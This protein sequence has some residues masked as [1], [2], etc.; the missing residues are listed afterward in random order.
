MSPFDCIPDSELLVSPKD[1]E[2]SAKLFALS[3]TPPDHDMFSL[4]GQR[5][6]TPSKISGP[7]WELF[8]DTICS[9]PKRR[10]R[11]KSVIACLPRR[12]EVEE[13][14]QRSDGE[15]EELQSVAEKSPG[16]LTFDDNLDTDVNDGDP[17]PILMKR[18]PCIINTENFALNELVKYMHPYC[19]PAVTMCLESEDDE[20]LEQDTVFLEIVSDER[21]TIKIPVVVEPP[22]EDMLCPESSDGMTG[23]DVEMENLPNIPS[24]SDKDVPELK[25]NVEKENGV[26]DEVTEAVKDVPELQD[27][28]PQPPEIKSSDNDSH[29]VGKVVPDCQKNS[30]PEITVPVI[31]NEKQPQKVKR[32]SKAKKPSKSKSKSKTKIEAENKPPDVP[33]PIP[34]RS[35][36]QPTANRPSNPSL[37]ES[38]LLI[39]TLDQVKKESQMDLRSSKAGRAKTR[40][41]GSL[42]GSNA[43]R[44]VKVVSKESEQAKSA[45]DVGKDLVQN[46]KLE[47]PDS[48][49]TGESAVQVLQSDKEI[50]KDILV[51]SDICNGEESGASKVEDVQDG[52]SSQMKDAKPKSL[53]LS[54]YRKR[55]QHRQ[56]KPVQD[57]ENP[58]YSRWPTVPEPPTEL[59]ELPCLIVPSQP[60]KSMEDKPC[61]IKTTNNPGREVPVSSVSVPMVS[62]EVQ[63][64]TAEPCPSGTDV[65]PPAMVAPQPS[66]PPQ[67]Y[68]SVWPAVPPPPSFYPGMPPMAG[69]HHYQNTLPSVFPVQ[70]PVMSWPPFPPPPIAV[71]PVHPTGW[72]SGPPTPYWSNAQ[73]AQAMSES[74]PLHNAPVTYGPSTLHVGP[75]KE[76][77]KK[78]VVQPVERRPQVPRI[79]VKKPENSVES[80][81]GAKP[82]GLKSDS[83][84]LL[85]KA[86]KS[87]SV[88]VPESKEKILIPNLKSANQ[89]V[90]QI[91]EILKKA[92]KLGFQ[93]PTSN[94]TSANAQPVPPSASALQLKQKVPADVKVQVVDKPLTRESPAP[95]IEASLKP[96]KLKMEKFPATGMG[97]AQEVA[98]DKVA[99]EGAEPGVLP[100][101]EPVWASEEM[102]QAAAGSEPKE[103][104]KSFT[105]ESGI[106]ATDLTSLLEQFEK[107]EAK[108]EERLPRSP[109]KLAVGNSGTGKTLEKMIHEKLLAPELVNTAGLTPPATPPH[110]LWKSAATGP[111]AGK[112]RSLHVQEKSY[113]PVKTAKL[114]EPKPLPQSRLKLRSV[115]SSPSV[116][117]PPVHVASG[118]HDYCIFSSQQEGNKAATTTATTAASPAACEEGSRWNV[119][120]HPNITIKPIVQFNKRQQIKACPKQPAPSAPSVVSNQSTT[121]GPIKPI[122]PCGSIQKA[123]TDP[124]DH[125]TNV[126]AESAVASAPA[127]VLMSPDSSPCRSETGASRTDVKRGNVSSRRALRCYRKYQGSPSPQ[128]SWRGRSSSSRSDSMSSSCSCSCSSSSSRSRSGSPASKRRRTSRY[129]SR[130]RH[131]SRSSSRSGYCSS[132]SSR[133]SSCSSRSCT[134]SSSRSRSRS[135]SPYERRCRSRSRRCESRESYNRRKIYHKERA[136]EER[137]VVY[138]GKIN[139]LMTRSELRRRFSVFGD[140][141]EC[142]IHFREEGDNYGFVTYRCT[143]EAFAAIENG[144]KLRLPGELPFDLCFGGRRQFC[145]STYADLDSHRDDFDPAPVRSKFEALDFD[146]LLKQ[147]Q[148]NHRR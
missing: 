69:V 41:R 33:E 109:D 43:D 48:V 90:S 52:D 38:D 82:E 44:N 142:T 6:A 47:N 2:G 120:H 103:P 122:A 131:R 107:T 19:L 71:P 20:N 118:D 58:S 60:K 86:A 104:E 99:S 136:I 35:I 144:H 14:Q 25:V 132:D 139:S 148:K 76:L 94:A 26:Q 57:L 34:A 9:T 79:V 115:G 63:Q 50:V 4:D 88:P 74:Q 101:A 78:G 24:S 105:C 106:E 7:N 116:A 55:L 22:P 53:S 102:F 130:S 111:V 133:S 145:K 138:I 91:M 45:V 137:R 32:S 10:T 96:E 61:P 113:S 62:Q 5:R 29:T 8:P 114:I 112:P 36:A 30:E 100:R 28:P 73:M 67:F 98:K 129:R 54:E 89:V 64:L 87:P 12:A 92:Q 80:K 108:E 40:T 11:C 77:L 85:M 147:A 21:E 59:A 117:V 81:N 126:M 127:S 97:T 121:C 15:D 84:S 17:E 66:V 51:P 110:Q 16:L 83:S 39:K 46:P 13:I 93:I 125:R 3:R 68:P 143:R 1:R 72:V 70:P 128:K 146:T 134:S 27:S 123:S 31:A 141:E 23:M 42:D 140:I 49:G 124:L 65:A 119:K 18:T 135:P 37:Q 56:P 95:V 75:E